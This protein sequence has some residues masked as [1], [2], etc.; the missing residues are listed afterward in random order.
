MD[1]SPPCTVSENVSKKLKSF[2]GTLCVVST[3]V[4]YP[5]FARAAPSKTWTLDARIKAPMMRDCTQ[6]RR[7]TIAMNSLFEKSD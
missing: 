4:W 2:K 5:G 7:E 3:G 6:V 1:P